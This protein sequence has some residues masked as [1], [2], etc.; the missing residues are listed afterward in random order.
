[1]TAETDGSN[2]ELLSAR[3]AR[4]IPGYSDYTASVVIA[5][6]ETTTDGPPPVIEIGIAHRF[7]VNLARNVLSGDAP[8]GSV[9]PDSAQG[10]ELTYLMDLLA[11]TQA[12]D[13]DIEPAIVVEESQEKSMLALL[14]ELHNKS[15][16]DGVS[17][18]RE[19]TE[20]EHGRT[21]LE[22]E[23]VWDWDLY[24]APVNEAAIL[25]EI[26]DSGIGSEELLNKGMLL[27]AYVMVFQRT[28]IEFVLQDKSGAQN[29]IYLYGPEDVDR[30]GGTH[31]F[32]ENIR[33]A[34]DRP[35][36]KVPPANSFMKRY[37]TAYQI[38]LEKRA[39]VLTMP[40]QDSEQQAVPVSFPRHAKMTGPVKVALEIELEESGLRDADVMNRAAWL[41]CF[42]AAMQRAGITILFADPSGNAGILPQVWKQ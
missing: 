40:T 6:S 14:A 19:Y 1:M 11:R 28:N 30:A 36:P 27:L 29:T 37:M 35:R 8:F 34:R 5:C 23:F 16:S 22:E 18:L 21:L 13:Y 12:D 10:M 7:A 26:E 42:C 38:E 39:A 41:Y 2:P 20:V 32:I 24:F 31:E 25:K 3:F 17:S 15:I 4:L 9:D 33:K